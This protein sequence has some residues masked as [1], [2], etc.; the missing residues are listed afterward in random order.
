MKSIQPILSHVRRAVDDYKMIE[1]GDRIAVGVSGGKDSMTLL[2]ALKELSRFYPKKY[3]IFAVCLDVGFPGGDLSPVE[4]LCERLEVP[5]KIVPTDIYDIVFEYRKEKCPCSLCARMRRGALHDAAK[6]LGC[7]KVALGHHFDDAVE[8]LLLNLFNEGR[9][10]CFSPV[11]FLD[12]KQITLIRPL[13]YT[14]EKM[15]T[16]FINKERIKL[17]PKV[18]PEDGN[19]DREKIKNLLFDLSK[20]DRGL[21][22]RIFGAMA[23]RGIDGWGKEQD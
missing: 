22:E 13:I 17:S 4:E 23:R 15:M 8:T 12:R 11:T 16:Y 20:N 18:C 3:E 7:G 19:T 2:C 21:K 1:D 6:A 5:L 9:I 10:G 14:P